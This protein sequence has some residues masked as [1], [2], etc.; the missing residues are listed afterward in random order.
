MTS[1]SETDAPS[2]APRPADGSE[3]ILYLDGQEYH[4]A[5][6]RLSIWVHHLLLPVYGREI[7]TGAPWCTRW[8][9]HPE[10]IAQLYGAWMAW[11]E[12]T[13]PDGGLTGPST[14]HRDHLSFAMAA[15]RDPGGPFAGCKP[16]AHRPKEAPPIER[17]P[18]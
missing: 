11:Q 15:L 6:T 16:N 9:E 18:S 4:E 1:T 7:T 14:W 17:F 12:L 8:W 5:L 3:F 13:S 2:T 10:A